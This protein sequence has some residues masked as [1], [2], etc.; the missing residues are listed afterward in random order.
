[1]SFELRRDILAGGL[2][3]LIRE[4]SGCFEQTSSSN[5]PNV[6]VLS[7]LEANG[8]A[9]PDL[10]AKTR[11]KLERGYNRLVGH[12]TKKKGYEWFGASPPHEALTAYGILQFEDMKRVST[13]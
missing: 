12:E 10:V 9:A 1:M 4:P 13:T 2:A 11:Q 6:M 3:G 5:Y 8:V 7:F